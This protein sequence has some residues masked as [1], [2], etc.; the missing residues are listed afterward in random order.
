M[1]QQHSKA[2]IYA[3]FTVLAALAMLQAPAVGAVPASSLSKWLS[4]R[5]VPELRER[6]G[7]H[8]RYEN[9]RVAVVAAADDGLTEA[10]VTVLLRSFPGQYGVQLLAW[11]PDLPAPANSIDGLSCSGGA[12]HDYLLRVKATRGVNGAGE[13]HLALVPVLES[14]AVSDQW[15]WNGRFTGAERRYLERTAQSPVRDGSL[16]SPWRETD[17]EVAARALV[18]EFACALRPQLQSRLALEWQQPPPLPAAFSDT[19]NIS[20]HLLGRYRELGFAEAAGAAYGIEVR[21]VPFQQNIW[22][23]WLLGVPRSPELAPL[24]AVTYFSAV[25]ENNAG[26]RAIA[27]GVSLSAAGRP[28]TTGRPAPGVDPLDF[29]DVELLDASQ[30]DGPGS[31]AALQVTLQLANRAEW[32]LE[33]SFTL[34]G[35]H[36]NH[37]VATPDYYRHDGYGSVDGRLAGGETVVRRLVIDGA[38]HNPRPLLGTRKCAGF[39]DLEGFEQFG[40]QGH[41]VTDYVR[42][43]M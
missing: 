18:R 43:Q 38:R 35:G 13:V 11:Q 8:P 37:C 23:L 40:R 42:W 9:Q 1:G 41:K 36:F 32:P 14:S 17:A 24:Q 34:S 6:L 22:Q 27:P 19:V 7:R 10:V 29:L 26:L 4:K 3:V 20:R 39:R 16:G 21:L 28:G 12:T 2:S 33:Y 25:L 31:R 30:A 15:R 5:A